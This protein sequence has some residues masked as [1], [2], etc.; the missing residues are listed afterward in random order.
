MLSRRSL[1]A[2]AASGP[3]WL[4]GHAGHA[5][6]PETINPAQPPVSMDQARRIAA[7]N[8]VVRVEEIKLDKDAWKVEGRDS[9]GAVIEISLRASDGVIIKMERERPAS[10]EAGRN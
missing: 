4:Q 3:F 1:L 10:A 5:Q 8:G 9:T 2:L 6:T 7:E